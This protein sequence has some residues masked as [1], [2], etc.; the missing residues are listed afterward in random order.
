MKRILISTAIALSGLSQAAEYSA[1]TNALTLVRSLVEQD[2]RVTRSAGQGIFKLP[3]G[4]SESQFLDELGE[5]LSGKSPNLAPV[6]AA[7]KA[8]LFLIYWAAAQIPETS[9]CFKDA[10]DP[11]CARDFDEAIEKTKSS[12]PAFLKNYNVARGPLGLPERSSV[13]LSAEHLAALPAALPMPHPR[14]L[15]NADRACDDLGFSAGRQSFGDACKR[16]NHR[17]YDDLLAMRSDPEIRIEFWGACQDAVGFGVSTN[18][19]GWSQCVK[20]VRA[21]CPASK[22]AGDNDR[23]RCLRA[24]QSNGW[25]LNSAAY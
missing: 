13:D 12:K 16:G 7:Q 19:L 5:W 6:P 3:A 15:V 8:Y 14:A 20:F 21:S 22:V 24:I 10:E 11:A 23:R 18:Y 4:E 9:S 17:G 1:N 25:V 2:L